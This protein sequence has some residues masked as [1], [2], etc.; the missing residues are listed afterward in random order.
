MCRAKVNRW[1]IKF[2][3][4]EANL[5]QSLADTFMGLQGTLGKAEGAGT[6]TLK[7]GM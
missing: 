3:T 6:T 7:A 2:F 1:L 4:F 5:I